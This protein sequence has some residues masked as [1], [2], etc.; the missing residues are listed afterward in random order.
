MNIEF[1]RQ[2]RGMDMS[3]V[4]TAPGALAAAANNIASIGST[5]ST[6]NSAA[7]AET[8][9][10]LA[11][12]A[13]EVSAAIAG[14]FAGHAQGYQAIAAQFS[15]FHDQFVQLLSG[16]GNAYATAEANNVAQTAMNAINAP[17]QSIFDR[18]LIGNG[19]NAATS[20]GAGGN[21]GLLIGTQGLPG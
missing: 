9:G 19:A 15:N 18:P 4:T 11:A 12:A 20:G 16:G 8:T 5:L 21:R 13:D 3:F 2:P 17:A 1:A 10:V 7:A 6:A 14:V